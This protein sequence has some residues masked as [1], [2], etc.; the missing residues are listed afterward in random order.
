MDRSYM[1]V[2]EKVTVTDVS[3]D[4]CLDEDVRVKMRGRK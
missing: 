3:S 2:K 4:R 1:R